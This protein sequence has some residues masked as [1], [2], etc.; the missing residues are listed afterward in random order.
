MI[1]GLSDWSPHQFTLFHTSVGI[2]R[3]VTGHYS[4][5]VSGYFTV[6][7]LNFNLTGH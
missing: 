7:L 3:D 2:I 5:R 4:G 6:S 1:C